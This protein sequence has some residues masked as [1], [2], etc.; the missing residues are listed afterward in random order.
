[1]KN[2]RNMQQ[3]TDVIEPEQLRKLINTLNSQQRKIFDDLIEREISRDIDKDPY[4]VFIAGDAGTGKSY[5][6]TVLMEAFKSVN[7]RSGKELGKPSILAMA[8]T[9]NAAYIISGQTIEAALGLSGTNYNYNKLSAERE[10]DIKFK[11]DEVSTL[12]IDEIS[13]VGSG[14]LTK[15][16]FRLQDIAKGRDRNFFLEANLVLQQVICGNCHQ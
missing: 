3:F 8:P 12:F 9:A 1:M 16:N 2:L 7:I 6:T 13:M 14:K 4:Y 15:I 11:Y 10:S 5:L